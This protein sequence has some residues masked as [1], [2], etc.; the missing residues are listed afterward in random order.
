MDEDEF[1][2]GLLMLIKEEE[3]ARGER[4]SKGEEKN[5]SRNDIEHGRKRIRL[6]IQIK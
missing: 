6:V 3:I 4:K 1:Q 5:G 2:V